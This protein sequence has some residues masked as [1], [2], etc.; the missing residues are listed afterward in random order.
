MVYF[1]RTS[2]F[3][4]FGHCFGARLP[5]LR[6]SGGRGRRVD[7]RLGADRGEDRDEPG[8]YRGSRSPSCRS[9]PASRPTSFSPSPSSS[10]CPG[11]FA[12][13]SAAILLM[14]LGAQW[15]I[16]FNVIAGA[17]AIPTDLREAMAAVPCQPSSSGGGELHASRRSSP[18]TSPA[19]SPPPAAP[20]TPRSSPR[21]P[22]T[23]S[24]TWPPP[25]SAP[26]SRR[27]DREG[28]LPE[29]LWASS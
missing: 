18:P 1:D 15:Y 9:W 27:A 12:Q 23:V 24:T 29:V 19:V 10:S 22:P 5:H 16:L 17:C 4:Q 20:G 28:R 13:L 11:I 6:A 25:A 26:T 14:A 21:S 7:C 2:G 8:F 3:G